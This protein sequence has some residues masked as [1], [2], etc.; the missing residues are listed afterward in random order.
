MI[1]DKLHLAWQVERLGSGIYVSQAEK[2]ESPAT[3]Q[4]EFCTMESRILQ[5]DCIMQICI[6][7]IQH[8]PF[9]IIY[10]IMVDFVSGST[11]KYLDFSI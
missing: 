11:L 2:V 5:A 9:C 4:S 8:P 6:A 10:L 7:L 3:G 1:A